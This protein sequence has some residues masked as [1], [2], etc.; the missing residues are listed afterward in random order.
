MQMKIN[1]FLS[2]AVT[3]AGWLVFGAVLGSANDSRAQAPGVPVYT[4]DSFCYDHF[5]AAGEKLYKAGKLTV[6]ES[7]LTNQ[8]FDRK[9]CELKLAAPRTEAAF[10]PRSRVA[11]ITGAASGVLIVAASA[12]SP[13]TASCLPA[14]FAYPNRAPCLRY[15]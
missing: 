7:V 14:I 13:R 1:S 2:L 10:P 8:L 15:P 5:M 4:D 12:F 3:A 6:G 9:S 11:A